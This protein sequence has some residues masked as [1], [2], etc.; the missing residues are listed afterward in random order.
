MSHFGGGMVFAWGRFLA[1]WSGFGV[2]GLFCCVGGGEFR[3]GGGMLGWWNG[4]ALFPNGHSGLLRLR[5]IVIP[6]WA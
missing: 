2:D 5:N 4:G 1:W 6:E 3:L